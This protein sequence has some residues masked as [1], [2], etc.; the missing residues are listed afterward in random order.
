M[1]LIW[2][3]CCLKV[4]LIQSSTSVVL[5]FELKQIWPQSRLSRHCN[6]LDR[7]RP[8]IYCKSNAGPYVYY[9]SGKASI[10][11]GWSGKYGLKIG[12]SFLRLVQL[13]V[14][15]ERLILKLFVK[16]M[17][18]QD[19]ICAFLICN[20]FFFSFASWEILRK[21]KMR[22]EVEYITFSFSLVSLSIM[23]TISHF[24]IFRLIYCV[25][26]SRL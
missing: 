18:V 20:V 8:E 19:V 23:E 12:L 24:F 13:K 10:E 1:Q 22:H 2:S 5:W 6:C 15:T 4:Q 16:A 14:I 7:A 9:Q 21:H 25:P 17:T 26:S 3:H 11:P